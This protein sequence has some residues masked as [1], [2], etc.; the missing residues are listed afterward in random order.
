MIQ[1]IGRAARNE[2]AYVCLYADEVTPQMAEAIEETERRRAKQLAYNAEHGITPKTIR[3]AIRRGIE[4]E[5]KARRTARGAI[6]GDEE[7]VDRHELLEELKK[8]MLEAAQGL[9]FEK[10]AGLRDQI[11]KIEAAPALTRVKRGTAKP[12][13]K[14]GTPGVKTRKKKSKRVAGKPRGT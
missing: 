12:E 7:E 3:K 2:N 11:K 1:Q 13:A 10:A 8:S 14:P 4:D 6:S 5:L 9:E